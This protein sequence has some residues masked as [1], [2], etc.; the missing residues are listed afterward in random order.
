MPRIPHIYP[1]ETKQG[2]RWKFVAS[3]G[4]DK[5]T[6]ERIRTEQGSYLSQNEA[7]E[8]YDLFIAENQK[9][10]LRSKKSILYGDFLRDY[11]LPKRKQELR[12]Q[13]YD[14]IEKEYRNY[15]MNLKKL[16]LRDIN[17]VVCQ[18][19]K[20]WLSEELKLSNNSCR[21]IYQELQKSLEFAITLGLINQN[22]AKRVGN[23]TKSK[24]PFNFWTLEEFRKVLATFPKEKFSQHLYYTTLW[25]FFFTGLRYGELQALEWSDINFDKAELSVNKS[26]Y[27]RSAKDW[28]VTPPKTAAGN[29]IIALDEATLNTLCEWRKAQHLNVGDLSFVISYNSLP[30]SRSS[31]T[32]V[33]NNHT[34]KANVKHIKIHELRHSHASLLISMGVNPLEIKERM[35]HEDIQTTLGVYSHLYKEANRKVADQLGELIK[36]ESEK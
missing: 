13:T 16:K 28:L 31:I 24:A 15:F 36:K 11:Y 35:G 7:K 14:G 10:P 19:F 23:F 30:M 26:M 6:G 22:W 25:L 33:I 1:Y 4:S 8:A 9:T 34:K 18:D 12:K 2:K 32:S 3:L 29:R 5:S 27:Y 20:K 17:G 21:N